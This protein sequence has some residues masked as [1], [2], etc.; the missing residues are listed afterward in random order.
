MGD[1]TIKVPEV[2]ENVTEGTIAQW[3]V[4]PG[5]SVVKGQPLFELA[6]DK[7]DSEVPSPFTG[8]IRE[9]LAPKG[10]VVGIGDAVAVID[11]ES[12]ASSESTEGLVAKTPSPDDPASDAEPGSP[13]D[14]IIKVP[15]VGENVTEGTIA[16]WLVEPGSSV[17]KG[18]PLFELATDKVDSEVPSPFTG[19]IREL[20]APKGSVV[21]IGDAVAV[22]EAVSGTAPT[23]PVAPAKGSA[24]KSATQVPA[25]KA[26]ASS[27]S[28]QRR[29][30]NDVPL[31]PMPGEGLIDEDIEPF[32]RIRAITAKVMVQSTSTI[33]HATSLVEADHHR[34][35][36]LRRELKAKGQGPLPTALAFATYAT[37]QALTRFSHLNASVQGDGLKIHSDINIAIAVDTDAGLIAPV[38]H[39]A[40]TLSVGDIAA[41]IGEIAEKARDGKLTA[42][43]ISGATFTISNNGSA[44]SLMTAAIITPPQVAVLSTD[45][46]V[47]RPVVVAGPDGKGIG[48]RPM[49]NLTMT[50]DHR[51]IDGALAAHFLVDIKNQLE[52]NDWSRL[53]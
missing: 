10:S 21:G 5:S 35:F 34:I 38:I 14:E 8:T 50:W 42:S 37:A 45:R 39:H 48:I 52:T 18:Q 23:K 9:L 40:D 19:T 20:L 27:L 15:E 43:D 6:T 2:G 3:L 41:A 31:P 7:V 1:E 22:I 28:A 4:E 47:E 25:K 32:S 44:G 16:Q 11:T 17:V 46:V 53:V 33:P 24:A 13:R 51:A 49:G 30:A 12:T 29:D 36:T 26:V